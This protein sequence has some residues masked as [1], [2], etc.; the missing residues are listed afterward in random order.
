MLVSASSNSSLDLKDLNKKW[1]EKGKNLRISQLK[2]NVQGSYVTMERHNSIFTIQ[3]ELYALTT[4]EVESLLKSQEQ[5]KERFHS[6][7]HSAMHGSEHNCENSY[8]FKLY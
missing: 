7:I 4:A 8:C 2:V 3:V 6:K 1:T 5:S